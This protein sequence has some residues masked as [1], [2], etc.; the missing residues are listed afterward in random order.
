MYSLKIKNYCFRS[1]KKRKKFLSNFVVA[2]QKYMRI[3]ALLLSLFFF[4]Q[5]NAQAGIGVTNPH[6]SAKLEVYATN[7]G[8]LPPRVTLT[9]ASDVTTIS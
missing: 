4:I 1:L 5:M 2:N 3:A 7:K 6:S 8:F 9:G